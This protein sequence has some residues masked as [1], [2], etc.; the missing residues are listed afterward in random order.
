MTFLSSIPYRQEL[1]EILNSLPQH[2][3]WTYSLSGNSEGVLVLSIC[4]MPYPFK[5][6]P[7]CRTAF[8]GWRVARSVSFPT[9]E[10]MVSFLRSNPEFL[11]YEI[12]FALEFAHEV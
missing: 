11:E 6:F 8:S 4:K 1:V 7:F 10:R 3:H 5:W 9:Y 2:P 12:S